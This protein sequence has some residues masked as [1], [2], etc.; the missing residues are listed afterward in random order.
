MQNAPDH[1]ATA[2]AHAPPR[3][4][5]DGQGRRWRAIRAL[6]GLIEPVPDA[7]RRRV[8]QENL[9]RLRLLAPLFATVSAVH[10]VVFGAM[11]PTTA[12]AVA[13]RAGILGAHATLLLVAVVLWAATRRTVAAGPAPRRAQL[14][15]VGALV[16]VLGAGVAIATVDQLV[17][18]SITPF[19][20]AN[21]LAGL[22]LVVTP[23]TTLV[24]YPGGVVVFAVVLPVVQADAAVL[25]SNQVNG[26]TAGAIGL[27]LALLRWRGEVRDHERLVEIERQRRELEDR[28]AELARLAAH[29]PLTGLHNRRQ[30]ELQFAQEVERHRRSGQPCSLL[31]LDLDEF[32]AVNDRYGHPAG[33]ALLRSVAA[34]VTDRLRASDLVAR[35]GGEEFLALLPGTARDGAVAVAEELRATF[36]DTALDAGP[37]GPLSITVSIGVAEVAVDEPDVLSHAYRRADAALYGA[38]L[39]GRDRVG[40]D[41]GPDDPADADDATHIVD[42]ADADDTAD[43]ADRS[44]PGGVG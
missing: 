33:D 18:S 5:A 12:D 9:R 35:W 20:V 11:S 15:T 44:V 7:L 43:P 16:V 23:R 37:S 21:A 25:A 13:W 24:A 17:T 2:G 1:T 6:P 31:L 10:L 29:D 22:I 30:F 4:G 42:A 36:R 8:Q 39:R 41:A 40:V 28:N 27:G 3:P 14:L 34:L 26:V 19:L 38:K 32:K